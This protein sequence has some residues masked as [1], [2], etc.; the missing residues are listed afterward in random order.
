MIS[1]DI[2]PAAP[3]VW[4]IVCTSTDYKTRRPKKF[5]VREIHTGGHGVELWPDPVGALHF[6]QYTKAWETLASIKMSG[7][8]LEEADLFAYY[9]DCA[10]VYGMDAYNPATDPD[11][12]LYGF[13]K[14]RSKEQVLERFIQSVDQQPKKRV[15]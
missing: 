9:D 11:S 3:K 10:K 12:K 14:P 5:Y 4:F 7:Y 2:T 6:E 1:Q 15:A 8:T 13:G